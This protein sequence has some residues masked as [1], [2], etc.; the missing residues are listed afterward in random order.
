MQNEGT[1]PLVAAMP[2]IAVAVKLL[3][4]ASI[5]GVGEVLLPLPVGNDFFC[6]RGGIH[7]DE[8]DEVGTEEG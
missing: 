1:R 2:V 8:R 3:E 5:G 7:N 6:S 4:V